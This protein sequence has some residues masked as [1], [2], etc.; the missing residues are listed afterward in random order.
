[1][2]T[3][4]HSKPPLSRT[5]DLGL[6]NDCLTKVKEQIQLMHGKAAV[7]EWL[8]EVQRCLNIARQQ[9]LEFPVIMEEREHYDADA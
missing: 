7:L 6:Y 8:N 3:F 9:A 5:G 4:R 2:H 1:M